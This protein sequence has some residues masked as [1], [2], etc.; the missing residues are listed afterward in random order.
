MAKHVPHRIVV[1]SRKV[2]PKGFTVLELLIVVVIFSIVMTAVMGTLITTSRTTFKNQQ[3]ADAQQTMRS[4]AQFITN[5]VITLGANFMGRNQAVTNGDYCLVKK[6]FLQSLRFPFTDVNNAGFDKIYAVQWANNTNSTSSTLGYDNP[7]NASPADNP[8]NFRIYP[9]SGPGVLGDAPN[10]IPAYGTGTDQLM[11]LQLEKTELQF[12]DGFGQTNPVLDGQPDIAEADYYATVAQATASQLV[13]SPVNNGKLPNGSQST[14]VINAEGLYD[15]SSFN[16]LLGPRLLP[17]VDC[18]VIQNQGGDSPFFLGVVTSVSASGDIT[19][20]TGSSDPIG[21]N[22]DW[23]LATSVTNL[24]KL[25][26]SQPPLVTGVN[27]R[28]SIRKARLI[29]YYIGSPKTATSVPGLG[30][31]SCILFR[32][33][34]AQVD[35][36]AF[37]IQNM[38][39]NWI[40]VDETILSSGAGQYYTIPSTS[41]SIADFDTLPPQPDPSNPSRTREWYRQAVRILVIHL[42]ARSDQKDPRTNQYYL[43]NQKFTVSLRNAAY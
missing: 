6:G 31:D 24:Q 36:V 27:S 25:G 40:V 39:F 42:F 18:L 7:S 17:Y 11:V 41:P 19:L 43:L 22:P 16:R 15:T 10:N 2:Q 9:G 35:P 1:H 23:S 3:I 8:A 30:L 4:S 21:L 37:N 32:R 38:Q 14:N 12:K 33:D 13:L 34:G 29:H 5:D 28:V 26:L 20:A